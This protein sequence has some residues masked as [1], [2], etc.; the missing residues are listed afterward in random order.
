M[1]LESAPQMD[2][3]AKGISCAYPSLDVQNLRVQILMQIY[4]DGAD[5][6]ALEKYADDVRI[7]GF[8]TNPALMKKAGIKDYAAFA[9][10]VLAIVKAKPVSFEVLSDDFYVIERQARIIASWGDNVV[11][12]I[13][14]TNTSGES[15]IP[16]IVKLQKDDIPV[17]VTAVMTM[18]QI[19][20]ARSV[21]NRG[22]ISIFAGRIADT[23][24]DPSH[25]VHYA[26]EYNKNPY[27]KILWASAREIFNI[28]QA[29]TAGA[30]I[31]TLTPDLITKLELHGKSLDKHSLDTV[32]MFYADG[33]G[34]EL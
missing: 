30:D 25:T 20:L 10:Y 4:L 7:H 11:V 34:I 5:L 2:N 29:E 24:R 18:R 12:K 13:P 31:I 23:G 8:T 28:S 17:N 1:R 9:R 32:A 26:K 19:D 27:V 3:G 33:Q 22:I 15:S 6:K 14:I 16:V 21:L